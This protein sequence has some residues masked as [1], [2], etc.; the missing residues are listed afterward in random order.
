MLDKNRLLRIFN[1]E[2]A[3]KNYDKG[4]RVLENDLVSSLD[5]TSEDNL[6]CIDGN[7]ISENL[8]NEYNTKIEM[9]ATKKS[10]FSTSCS[11]PDYEKNEFKKKNYCCKHLVA[12]FYKA[13]DEL[14][15]HPLL[16]EEM[17]NEEMQE[18]QGIFKSRD[19]VVSMLLGD[20]KHKDEIK[21]EVYINRNEWKHTISAE[22]KIGL[23]SISSNNLYILKDIDHFL[24]SYY[25]RIPIKYSKNFTF[26]IGNQKLSIKDKRLIDF[27]MMLK[28][29][30]GSQKYVNRT[31]KKA[32]DGKYVNIPK[33]LVR[34]FFEVIR[35]HRVYLNEG[36]FYRTVETEILQDSPAINFDLKTVKDNYVLKS[37]EGMPMVLSSKNDAFLYGTT[38]YIPDYEFCYKISPYVKVFKEAKVVT[39]PRA[40]E[41]T[42]LR[43]LIPNLNFLTPNVT[44]SKN[45]KD[46]I[47]MDEC[48]FNFYFDQEGKNITLTLKVKY[49]AFEFNI[50]EDYNG[51][52]IY[53]DS[54]KE[55]DAISLLRGLGFEGIDGKFYLLMG[56]DYIFRFFKS[57]IGKLQE[58]GDVYYSENFKGIKS[59]GKKGISGD[60][61]SG[62]YNYFEMDFK[63]GDISPQET[64]KILRA[65]RDNL[66]YYKLDNGEYLDLEELELNKF[67]KL[68]DVV[69]NDDIDENYIK[70]S[71]SKGAFIDNYLEEN[72]IRYI[73]GKKELKE[74][75][76]KFKNIE[77]LKFEVP[78]DLNGNLREYQKLGYNWLKT[79]DYLGFGGILGDEMGLGKTLQTI[80][81]ILSNKE[82]KSLIVAPTSLIYNWI[83]EFKKFA[84]SIKAV[85]VNGSREEREEIIKNIKSYD[86]VITTYNL[87]KRDS[88]I[89]KSIEFDY[90]IL[91]EAQYI[92]NSSSQNAI[93]VK[94]IKAKTRFALSGTPIENS[95]M[96]LWSIFDF[97]MPG[98]L[99]DE[100][101]F[102]VR[103]HKKLKESPEVLEELN[104]L[105]KPFILRRRKK[106]VIKELPDKIE[107]RLLVSLDD[108]QKKVYKAYANYAVELIEK[109]VR[110]DEFKKSKIEILSYITKLRQLCL[111]PKVLIEDYTGGSGKMEALVELL[112][113]S[114]EEGHRILI[115][116]QFTSVLKN[117][118]KRLE[119]ESIAFSY[120][121]GSIPSEKRMNMVKAF[122]EGENSVF[123]I[124]LKAGGTGINLTSADVVVHFDP[125]WNPAVE[126]QATDRAHRIGQENV[127]EV[128]KIIAKGTIE[129]KIIALQ[130]EKK[131]LI[132]QLMGDELSGGEGFASL[133]D[134]E[135]LGLFENGDG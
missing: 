60:I 121:D 10:I 25:N 31:D 126:E 83:N 90:C 34:E 37:S 30:E 79:L 50:F 95:L 35:K 61:K 92:K 33:Y 128:I 118:G 124:S 23:N 43:K 51:K 119:V 21:I 120:L 91:D 114:I 104:R 40:E 8:F 125:W 81:F 74:I 55:H 64:S 86:V 82:K 9:D 72:D 22:F 132:S 113:Q 62:K 116:S 88:D 39:I 56:D 85:A 36:F 127:V 14:A 54:K 103:Y 1:E 93:S 5:I 3:G 49:G 68:L 122:N 77:K 20:E 76:D 44:L 24:V 29:I 99:Y 28:E 48:K 107:K 4:Q 41:E 42:I 18:E 32:V 100:K 131:K 75:R 69:S 15:E 94:D 2:T 105:I 73:K 17:I 57:E 19:N 52:I 102:S 6:I 96:E 115:F 134:E 108:E 71:K 97:I 123:L 66:K 58:I 117:I 59:I 13:I 27:I 129:E 112:F 110:N 135:I 78:K 70:I 16:N 7:V 87:L 84:P 38:I 109:K 45:I 98:Y 63:I 89:Y 106:D 12:T 26:D 47:V 67:L 65:F 11:C 111:D 80:A 101:R 130:E 46:K 53:R 133:S